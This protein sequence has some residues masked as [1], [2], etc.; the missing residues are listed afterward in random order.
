MQHVC[1]LSGNLFGRTGEV[2]CIGVAL[3]RLQNL[4]GGRG[5]AGDARLGP[6]RPEIFGV[7]DKAGLLQRLH[8][9]D[10]LGIA[11]GIDLTGDGD[12]RGKLGPYLLG[13]GF[14]HAVTDHIAVLHIDG[15]GQR[16]LRDAELGRSGGTRLGG[17]AVDGVPAKEQK[18]VVS[19][20]SGGHGQRIGS[21][22]GVGSAE[23][24]VGEKIGLVTA[25]C[26]RLFQDI[27][28]LRWAH[29][30][31]AD[32]SAV[33][34]FQLDG[35]LHGIGIQRIELAGD[36]FAHDVAGLGIQF[37]IIRV[38]DL[39]DKYQNLH[40]WKKLLCEKCTWIYLP[41]TAPLMTMRRISLVPSPISR[42]L[43]SR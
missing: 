25:E 2:L 7:P 11:R 24:P 39:F 27:F 32:L 12:Q 30:D 38:G 9:V 23:S 13:A 14:K 33:F 10:G 3:G 22:K 19:D 36:T 26:Q 4:L 21:R 41:I 40:G 8:D 42:S 18:I 15:R 37:D 28:R 20:L 31:G 35:S 1:K 43:A 29:A 5:R 16:D 6:V 17:V 34:L